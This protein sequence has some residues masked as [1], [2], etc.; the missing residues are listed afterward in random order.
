M[1]LVTR[2]RVCGCDA[3][4]DECQLWSPILSEFAKQHGIDVWRAPYSMN[5]GYLG[6]GLITDRKKVTASYKLKWRFIMALKYLQVRFRLPFIT[7]FVRLF[8]E[9]VRNTIDL[10][11]R[12]L[13]HT[14]KSVTV[15][16]TKHYLKAVSLYRARPESTRIIVLSRDGRGVFH[17]GLKRGLSRK[18]SLSFWFNYYNRAL[19]LFA[20]TV[21]REHIHMVRYEDLVTDPKRV[22]Q[23]V[24]EFLGLDFDERM[25]DFRSVVHH[26]VNGNKVKIGSGSELTLDDAWRRELSPANSAHFLHVAGALNKSLGYE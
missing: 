18:Y 22:L 1:D 2:R 14:G 10:Y 13:Q 23:G 17:S 21:A 4:F 6:G 9:G 7:P 16:S 20:S 11:D 26:N 3:H 12:V 24:C 8:D 5:L 15:D 25:L 19:P